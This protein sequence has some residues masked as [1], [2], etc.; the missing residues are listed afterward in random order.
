MYVRESYEICKEIVNIT[1]KNAYLRIIQPLHYIIQICAFN[2]WSIFFV[3]RLN[4][5]LFL[6]LIVL[7]MHDVMQ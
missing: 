5:R 4:T 2:N 7:H 3:T 6:L 1:R